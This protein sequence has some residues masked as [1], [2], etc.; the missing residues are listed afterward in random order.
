ML[1][2]VTI[3]GKRLLALLYT[4]ST[5]TFLQGVAMRCLG[6]AP[7]GSDQLR[8]TVANSERVSCEGITCYVPVDISGVPLSSPMWASCWAALTSSS[9][10]TSSAR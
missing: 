2:P 6:L 5:H 7:Q 1:L 4:G 10:S 9:A 3:K 8:I